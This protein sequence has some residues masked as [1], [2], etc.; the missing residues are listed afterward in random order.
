MLIID[1]LGGAVEKDAQCCYRR[2]TNGDANSGQVDRHFRVS[3]VRTVE[4]I[5]ALSGLGPLVS[6]VLMGLASAIECVTRLHEDQVLS[7]LP[8]E[9]APECLAGFVVRINE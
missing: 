4:S 9:V 3:H 1:G 2:A 5:P 7:C 6:V 8:I